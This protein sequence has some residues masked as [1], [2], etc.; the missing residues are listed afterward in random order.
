VRANIASLPAD[1]E[2]ADEP[3]KSYSML[4]LALKV[5]VVEHDMLRGLFESP[6]PEEPTPGGFVQ[7]GGRPTGYTS[8]KKRGGHGHP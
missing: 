1:G 6:S 2:D 3:M 7:Q 8:G 5:A 4:D